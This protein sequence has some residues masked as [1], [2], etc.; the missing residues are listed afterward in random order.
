MLDGLSAIAAITSSSSAD[1]G[2]TILIP[3]AP[4][5]PSRTLHPP[6]TMHT[7]ITAAILANILRIALT[8]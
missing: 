2:E 8:S 6:T 3:N 1:S 5:M 7:H 4:A